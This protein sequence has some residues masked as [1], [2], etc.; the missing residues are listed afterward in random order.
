MWTKSPDKIAG[1][2]KKIFGWQIKPMP[3]LNYNLVDTGGQGGINGGIM[4]PPH[5]GPWP[6]NMTLYIDVEDLADYRQRVVEAGG[7]ILI[8]EQDVGG[9]G[10]F[11]LVADPDGR[12][13]G[14]WKHCEK[15]G[16]TS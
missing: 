3:E 11:S 5:E 2:Y 14:L 10:T 13:I 1:F 16:G 12:P 4:T 9:M 6:G 15:E 8:K 7:K